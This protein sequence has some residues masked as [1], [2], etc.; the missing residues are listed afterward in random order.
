MKILF[1]TFPAEW[2]T[3]ESLRPWSADENS[4]G[5]V[6]YLTL[7]TKMQGAARGLAK[8]DSLIFFKLASIVA[9]TYSLQ[10]KAVIGY[11]FLVTAK[12]VA[13]FGSP[14]QRRMHRLFKNWRFFCAR[15][16]WKQNIHCS[17]LPKLFLACRVGSLVLAGP[18]TGLPTHSMRLFCLEAEKANNPFQRSNVM[19]NLFTQLYQYDLTFQCS[20]PQNQKDDDKSASKAAIKPQAFHSAPKILVDVIY[21]FSQRIFRILLNSQEAKS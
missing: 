15:N 3:R 11:S 12:S 7:R 20:H 14:I 17:A 1:F 21:C 6:F 4:A 10:I 13:G 5:K 16:T 2:G 8:S 19:S 18:L 9:D